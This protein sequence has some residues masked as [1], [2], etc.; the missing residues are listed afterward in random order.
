MRMQKN[1]SLPPAKSGHFGSVKTD[2]MQA[3]Q[4]YNSE[5]GTPLT[6]IREKPMIS[7]RAFVKGG[8]DK[9]NNLSLMLSPSKNRDSL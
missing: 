6:A 3:L 4:I 5:F 7:D 9:I 8:L 1:A 2:T